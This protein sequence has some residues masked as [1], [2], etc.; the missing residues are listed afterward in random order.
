MRGWET[1]ASWVDLSYT[2][3]PL[4]QIGIHYASVPQKA[5]LFGHLIFT[6]VIESK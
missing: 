2:H 5:S 4:I 1:R 6:D 3:T